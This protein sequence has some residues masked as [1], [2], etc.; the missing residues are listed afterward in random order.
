MELSKKGCGRDPLFNSMRVGDQ[1]EEEEE[2]G[3]L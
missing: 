3:I 2:E 1:E